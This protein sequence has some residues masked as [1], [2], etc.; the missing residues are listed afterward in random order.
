MNPGLEA[1]GHMRGWRA[2]GLLLFWL[3][4]AATG[5]GGKGKRVGVPKNLIGADADEVAIVPSVSIALSAIA[6]CLRFEKRRK[7]VLS[8]MDFPT[9]H[10]VWRAQE[11]AGARLEI[12]SSTDRV[13]IDARRCIEIE[14]RD[15]R[16]ACFE[17]EVDE[18]R[19]RDENAPAPAA[20]GPSRVQPRATL[21]GMTRHGR[22]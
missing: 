4:A 9:N 5:A 20:A 11:R 3:A 7:V 19:E 21:G 17:A 13:T 15:E 16:L 22:S 14:S 2:H 8:E 18:A 1:V 12:V 6:S 10:Y